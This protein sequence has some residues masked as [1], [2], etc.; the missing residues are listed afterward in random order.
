MSS[1]FTIA[2]ITA[3]AHGFIHSTVKLGGEDRS[4]EVPTG[5]PTTVK[6]RVPTPNNIPPHAKGIFFDGPIVI[7]SFGARGTLY[8]ELTAHDLYTHRFFISHESGD[9]D[10][11]FRMTRIVMHACEKEGDIPVVITQPSNS[12][13]KTCTAFSAEW[14]KS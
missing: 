12:C 8:A 10:D 2:E 6:V 11:L 1:H 5:V 9:A 7:V 14:T 13:G 4:L 3:P